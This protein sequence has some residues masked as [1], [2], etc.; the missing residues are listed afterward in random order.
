MDVNINEMKNG[1][2]AMAF[3]L[4][5]IIVYSFMALVL[6]AETLLMS[7]EKWMIPLLLVSILVVWWIYIRQSANSRV[8]LYIYLTMRSVRNYRVVKKK[9]SLSCV[10]L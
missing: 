4:V 6:C 1:E 3:H 7:W 9:E 8:R 10:V 5:I 2:K